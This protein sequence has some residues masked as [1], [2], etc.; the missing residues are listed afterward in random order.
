M[1]A[2]IKRRIEAIRKANPI[3]PAY[4]VELTSGEIVMLHGAEVLA[5]ALEGKVMKITY[6]KGATPDWAILAMLLS[7]KA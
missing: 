4:R 2:E 3:I 6:C 1:K 5:L 7:P